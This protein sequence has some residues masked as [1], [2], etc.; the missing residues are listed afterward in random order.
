M[1]SPSHYVVRTFPCTTKRKT[2]RNNPGAFQ[3]V[4]SA[5]RVSAPH[6]MNKRIGRKEALRQSIVLEAAVRRSAEAERN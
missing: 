3:E 5:L 4:V 1:S 6:N 2:G